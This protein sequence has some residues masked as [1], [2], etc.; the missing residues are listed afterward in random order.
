MLMELFSLV[1]IFIGLMFLLVVGVILFQIVRG[2][3]QWAYNNGQPVLSEPARVVAKRA[4]TS[5]HVGSNTGGMISTAYFV[6][7]ESQEGERREFQVSGRDH[8]TLVDGDEG[9]LTFQG[10]RY[11]GFAR[12]PR[13]MAAHRRRAAA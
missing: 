1:P 9:T 4:E 12:Q 3:G 10:S 6:T 11:K 13:S 7:F 2:I 5:G 8:G